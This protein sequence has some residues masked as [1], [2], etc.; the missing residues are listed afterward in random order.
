MEIPIFHHAKIKSS[1]ENPLKE[2]KFLQDITT[3]SLIPSFNTN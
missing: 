1:K 3:L 2:T